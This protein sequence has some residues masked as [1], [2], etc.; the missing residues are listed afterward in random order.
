MTEQRDFAHYFRKAIERLGN[1]KHREFAERTLHYLEVYSRGGPDESGTSTEKAKASAAQAMGLT[2]EKREEAERELAIAL[3]AVLLS[4]PG[5]LEAVMEGIESTPRASVSVEGLHEE[6]LSKE[7]RDQLLEELTTE[8]LALRDELEVA[9]SFFST[10]LSLR[11]FPAERPANIT[12]LVSGVSPTRGWDSSK[13][14]RLAQTA[15][16]VVQRYLPGRPV[17]HIL[18][19]SDLPLSPFDRLLGNTIEG[20]KRRQ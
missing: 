18:E 17:V 12:I 9:D 10:G 3:F 19:D 20:M 13:A 11:S 16:S 1:P 8:C 4:E 14:E 2:Q 7:L 5:N 15:R 6:E